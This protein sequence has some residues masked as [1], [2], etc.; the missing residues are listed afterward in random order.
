MSYGFP[1]NGQNQA[2]NAATPVKIFSSN[3]ARQGVRVTNNSGISVYIVAVPSGQTAPTLADMVTNL[4]SYP[5]LTSGLFWEDGNRTADVYA[6]A[7]SGNPSVY[8]E[9][10]MP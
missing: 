7:A 5:V 10:L 6:I 8:T 2:L 1:A 9:E 4:K 3:R